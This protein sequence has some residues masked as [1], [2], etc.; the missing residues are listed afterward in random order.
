MENSIYLFTSAAVMDLLSQLPELADK[1]L[2]LVNHGD[3]TMLLTIDGAQ[4]TLRSEEPAEIQV[5]DDDVDYAQAADDAAFE[6][7]EGLESSTEPIESGILKHMV[8]AMLLGGMV[9]LTSK[10]L[11]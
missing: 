11:K 2:E 3:G 1:D 8:K 6:D 4:Y 10:L 9:K 7:I 5:S